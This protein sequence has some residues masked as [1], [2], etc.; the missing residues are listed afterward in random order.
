MKSVFLKGNQNRNG[1]TGNCRFRIFFT[2]N[3]NLMK[4]A[5]TLKRGQRSFSTRKFIAIMSLALFFI[6]CT[7]YKLQAQRSQITGRIT[8]E[9][10]ESLRGATVKVK[11]SNTGTS[12]D[13]SGSFTINADDKDILLISYVGYTDIEMPINGQHQMD[14]KLTLATKE[15]NQVVVIGYGSQRKRNVTGAISTVTAADIE[16]R[17]IINTAEALQGKASGVQVTSNSGKPGVGLTIRIRGSSSI[18]AG[19]D[20][21]YIVDG[22]PTTDIAAYNPNDVESISV[23][24]DAASAAI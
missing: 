20:P 9:Q 15:L 18:S 19:N 21:L 7:T 10:G 5:L 4:K 16:K 12:T 2:F 8:G 17:P 23:L 14:I 22:I 24:K 13:S 11:G 3:S 6:L 1:A